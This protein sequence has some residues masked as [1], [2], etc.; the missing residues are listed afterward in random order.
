MPNAS[1][2]PATLLRGSRRLPPPPNGCRQK[3]LQNEGNKTSS[4]NYRGIT[5]SPVL[6][7]LFEMILLID[8]QKDL[9]SDCLQF[10]FKKEASCS[11]A[12]FTLRSVVEHYCKSGSTVTLCA[13]DI[14]KAYDRV[15]QYALLSLLMDRKVPKY[16]INIML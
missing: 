11:Q 9:K 7:K 4:D 5:L 10:G 3:V 14:S 15:D 1:N 13:Q 2:R 16:F 8:L 12:I 6:S